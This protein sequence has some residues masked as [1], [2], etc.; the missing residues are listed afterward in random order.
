M[1]LLYQEIEMQLWNLAWY[2][3]GSFTEVTPSGL[4]IPHFKNQKIKIQA[5]LMF[6]T[7]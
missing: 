5:G 1:V 2:I 4:Q 7:H 6:T 3:P